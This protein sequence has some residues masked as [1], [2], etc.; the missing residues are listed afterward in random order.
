M[1]ELSSKLKESRVMVMYAIS[2]LY[3]WC[4]MSWYKVSSSHIPDRIVELREDLWEI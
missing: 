1:R 3:T 4:G 2:Y